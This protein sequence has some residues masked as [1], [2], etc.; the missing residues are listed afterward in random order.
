MILKSPKTIEILSYLSGRKE[1]IS[2]IARAVK[3]QY[4]FTSLVMKR[5]EKAGLVNKEEVGK[6]RIITLTDKGKQIS[7]KLNEIKSLL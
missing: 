1:P 3:V 6:L 2:K 5:L 4:S 7:N